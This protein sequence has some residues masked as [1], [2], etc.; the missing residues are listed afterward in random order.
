MVDANCVTDRLIM[1]FQGT[2]LCYLLSL[3]IFKLSGES[4]PFFP[5]SGLACALKGIW[6]TC[7]PG[8]NNWNECIVT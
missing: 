7:F 1:I 3:P 5:F 2:Y 6:I 4:A 8:Y